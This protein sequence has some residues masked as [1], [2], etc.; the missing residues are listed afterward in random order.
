MWVPGQE[1]FHV[2]NPSKLQISCPMKYRIYAS[3][4]DKNVPYFDCALRIGDSTPGYP[5]GDQEDQ[6]RDMAWPAVVDDAPS[7]GDIEADGL[8]ALLTIPDIP[9]D[10][11]GERDAR[12]QDLAHAH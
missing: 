5:H 1:P 8:D 10:E 6:C 4:V 11:E 7:K 2:T 3:S 9:L 12:R